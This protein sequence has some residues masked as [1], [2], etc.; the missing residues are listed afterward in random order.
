MSSYI[1][2]LEHPIV[3]TF[4]TLAGL[5]D[6]AEPT[7][8]KIE[9]FPKGVIDHSLQ[10]ET[11]QNRENLMKDTDDLMFAKTYELTETQVCTCDLCLFTST[12]IFL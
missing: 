6:D 10:A 1:S 2:F 5:Q 8:S 12:Q 3:F 9:D 4:L 7:K 11:L